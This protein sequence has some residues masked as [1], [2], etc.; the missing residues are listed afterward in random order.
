MDVDVVTV[1]VLRN[2]FNSIAT[3]MNRNMARS[4]YSPIIYEM[5]DCSVALFDDE[6]RMLGQST[7]L[8]VFL[9]SLEA[10]VRAI[11]DHFGRRVDAPRRCL[12]RQRQLHRRQPPQRRVGAVADLLRRRA[13]RLRGDEGALDRHRRQEPESGDGLDGDL[14]G[15]LRLGPTKVWTRGRSG[16]GD[17]R[18]DLR[19]SRVP[20]AIKGDLTPRSWPAAPA[21][22]SSPSCS[23]ASA[24]TSWAR[25]PSR[26]SSSRERRRPR[27]R[28]GD[29]RRDLGAEGALDS[30]GPGGGPVPV[31]GR[32][33]DRR[34]RDAPR[35]ARLVA[36]RPRVGSTAGWPRRS[37]RPAS[38]S[39]SWSTRT[40]R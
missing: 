11:L 22:A 3:Q 2:A 37:P 4:A 21:S 30:W 39:S 38:P 35:P 40:C 17:R 7:G 25:R 12:P 1:E 8:P 5:K 32:G 23:S 26:S 9:G 29:A 27:V 6:A 36:A 13:R 20:K 19:N 24:S 16:A 14:P 15:G 28:R 18:A 10:A 33:D 31:R 34:R